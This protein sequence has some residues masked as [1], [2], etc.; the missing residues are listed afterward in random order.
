MESPFSTAWRIKEDPVEATREHRPQRLRI[1]HLSVDTGDSVEF[2]NLLHSRD[3]S[4]AQI[5][6]DQNPFGFLAPSDQ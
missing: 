5:V 6:G 2:E 1:V 3:A 4:S